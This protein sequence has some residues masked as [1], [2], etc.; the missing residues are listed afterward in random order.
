MIPIRWR[1]VLRDLGS[2]KTRTLLVLLSIAVGVTAIGMVLGSQIIV[3]ESLPEAY[4]AVNP[5][6]GTLFA[7]STFDD[8]MVEA[9]RAMPEVG[10]AEGRRFVNVRFLT[11]DGEWRSMQLFAIP[12]FDDMSINKINSEEGAFPPPERTLVIERDSFR[13]SLGLGDV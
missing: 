9:I 2:N 6:S 10:E 3:D 1:K 7:I 12:D 4:A 13:A 5:A 11:G 8:D